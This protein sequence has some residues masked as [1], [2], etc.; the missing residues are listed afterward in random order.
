MI[1]VP[2]LWERRLLLGHLRF[3]MPPG[4]QSFLVFFLL[5]LLA[6]AIISSAATNIQMSC[7]VKSK[8]GHCTSTGYGNS[9]DSNSFVEA[10]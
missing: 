7:R 9:N 8:P 4:E 6:L 3:F 10:T 2:I 5:I 1:L